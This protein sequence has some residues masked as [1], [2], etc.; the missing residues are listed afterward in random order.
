MVL[1]LYY[2]A[3]S[4]VLFTM[5]GAYLTITTCILLLC[6]FLLQPGFDLLPRLVISEV[7]TTCLTKFRMFSFSFCK[8]NNWQNTFSW[9]L[10]HLFVWYVAMELM[11]YLN[12]CTF[13]LI[14][15]FKNI[16]CSLT[17]RKERERE[18]HFDPNFL[19]Q[20]C[21]TK[22][23]SVSMSFGHSVNQNKWFDHLSS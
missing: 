2:C 19:L 21:K 16:F 20:A 17:K 6:L 3:K 18:T 9:E 5:F 11:G 8:D 22:Y 15:V 10:R 13:H 4:S 7:V 14:I 23:C 12:E 1:R